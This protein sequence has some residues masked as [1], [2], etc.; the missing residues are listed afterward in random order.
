MNYYIAREGWPFIG[1][2]LAIFVITLTISSLLAL[3]FLALLLFVVWFF[4]NPERDIPEDK[5]MLVSPADGTVLDVLPLEGGGTRI[6]IFMSVFNVHV[7]RIPVS[8]VIKKI[9][10][11]KGK[12]LVASMDKASLDNEQN[13]I[14]IEEEG[15]RTVKF[16]QIA[17]LVA[18]RIVCYLKE[19][20]AVVKGESFGM[21]RFGSRVDVYIS[22][23]FSPKVVKGEKVHAGSTILGILGSGLTS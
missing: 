13:A 10:Y 18:R 14:T 22:G 7:N 20:D 6:N 19:G 17:G 15:G 23:V 12:F 1:I 21:I 2:A 4:R 8:G 16:V 5:S 11:N 9:D 3:P